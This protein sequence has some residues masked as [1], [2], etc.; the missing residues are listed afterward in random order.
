MN[1]N[2]LKQKA[3]N[4]RRK[5]FDAFIKYKEAHLGGSFSMIETLLTIY[6]IILKKMTNLFSVKLMPHFHYAYC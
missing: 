4:L 6:E 3:K 5:T 1:I 2:K